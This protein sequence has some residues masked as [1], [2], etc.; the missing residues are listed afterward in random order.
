MKQEYALHILKCIG[1]PATTK[2]VAMFYGILNPTREDITMTF[3]RLDA[4]RRFGL[5]RKITQG[6]FKP[7]YWEVVE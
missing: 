7:A 2:E 4:L 3:A 5:V 1:R 6:R